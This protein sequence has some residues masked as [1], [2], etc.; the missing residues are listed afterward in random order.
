MGQVIQKLCQRPKGDL[1]NFI[2]VAI[3]GPT[4]QPLDRRFV[5]SKD[6]FRDLGFDVVSTG[7]LVNR[8]CINTWK[9]GIWRSG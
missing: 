7:S 6:Q 3:F 5:S 8:S 4:G 1:D 9:T 2:Q